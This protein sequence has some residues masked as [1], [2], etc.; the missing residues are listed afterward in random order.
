MNSSPS[1]G[2]ID[3]G[4][5]N[6]S[7]FL[8]IY[9]DLGVNAFP[10]SDEPS[11]ARASHLI[12]PGVGSFD[13]AISCLHNIGIYDKLN[14]FVC[15]IGVPIL[16]VCVGFQIMC[17]TS[18]EG[19][20]TGLSWLD[21]DVRTLRPADN[22]S[23]TIKLIL[24]HMGWNLVSPKHLH[25]P[26]FQGISDFHFYFLHSYC[27]NVNSTS[28]AIADSLYGDQFC[29]AAGASNV[30]GVQFHPEKSHVAGVSLLKNF[31][32]FAPC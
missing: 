2:V 23:P 22:L 8:N 19:T 5:G 10:V 18:E 29:C 26:L 4:L 12:L 27:V 25:H 1:I 31:S 14:H 28:I 15:D 20:S 6:I 24:P 30:L 13:W 17:K 11:F 9:R 16:G 7:A 3:Y 32:N 21:A